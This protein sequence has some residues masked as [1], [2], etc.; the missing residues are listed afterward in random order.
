MD[1]FSK[2]N[3]ASYCYRVIAYRNVDSLHSVSNV[4]CIPTEFR[5]FVPNSFT[6]NGDGINDIFLPKGIFVSEYNLQIFN[7]WG[8]KLFESDDINEGWD[9]KFKGEYCQLGTYYYQL[10]GTG[11]NGDKKTFNGPI[12]LLR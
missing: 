1:S 8:E 12:Q 11:T 9:G 7:R 10:I 4:V 5:L 2:F 3:S 6:P